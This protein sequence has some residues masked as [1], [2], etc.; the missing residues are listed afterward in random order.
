M[1]KHIKHFT[2]L[3]RRVSNTE[4]GP[5][6]SEFTQDWRCQD[7]GRL[8][9]KTNGVQMQIR[10]KPFD[11]VVGFPVSATCPGCGS[12]NVTNTKQAR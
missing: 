4:R 9:G 6:D 1:T 8:L 10:R 3:S 11:Y 12:L 5:M 2:H 7:C